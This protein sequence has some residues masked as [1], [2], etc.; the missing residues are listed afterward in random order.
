MIGCDN[1]QTRSQW[2]VQEKHLT[3]IV[4]HL[5]CSPIHPRLLT[6]KVKF[7]PCQRPGY[8]LLQLSDCM[9]ETCMLFGW[10]EGPRALVNPVKAILVGVGLSKKALHQGAWIAEW[11]HNRLWTLICFATTWAV[12]LSLGSNKH[13]IGPRT[14]STLF[15]WSYQLHHN[16]CCCC[17]T[18]EIVVYT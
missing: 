10:G 17:T 2:G 16:S 1:S 14:T 7:K 4:W 6:G 11:Y 18:I 5:I 13:F 12:S 3:K 15:S 9:M 8:F